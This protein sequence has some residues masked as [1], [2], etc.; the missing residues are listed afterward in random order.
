MEDRF[1]IRLDNEP[2]FFTIIDAGGDARSTP[3]P[4][5][6]ASL[7]YEDADRKCREL[8]EHGFPGAYVTD[9]FGQPVLPADIPVE[10][11][12]NV[13]FRGE[14]PNMIEGLS[15]SAAVKVQRQLREEGFTDV[16]IV[17]S[18]VGDRTADKSNVVWGVNTPED[19]GVKS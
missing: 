9:R 14:Q 17:R 16:Q 3:Y 12:Y 8:R 7:P 6:A 1:L 11:K 10:Q 4:N 13:A 2:S 19:T 5:C 15:K 18:I